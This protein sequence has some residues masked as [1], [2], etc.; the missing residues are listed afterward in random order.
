[1]KDESQPNIHEQKEYGGKYH[2]IFIVVLYRH[3]HKNG[4]VQNIDRHIH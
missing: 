3:S 4:V 2:I 1:M